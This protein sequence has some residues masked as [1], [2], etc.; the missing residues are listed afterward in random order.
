M[1]LTG[2]SGK[3]QA[4]GGATGENATGS[5]NSLKG[6]LGCFQKRENVSLK[7]TFCSEMSHKKKNL[8]F[9]KALYYRK[10]FNV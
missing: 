10:L 8:C 6:N 9:G 7:H 1:H 5:Q 4:P 3:Q 2:R